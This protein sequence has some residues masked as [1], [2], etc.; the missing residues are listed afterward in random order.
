MADLS[1]EQ[2]TMDRILEKVGL[3]SQETTVKEYGFTVQDQERFTAGKEKLI[4]F[5]DKLE[6][7]ASVIR[8]AEEASSVLGLGLQDEVKDLDRVIEQKFADFI[9]SFYKDE[10]NF[11]YFLRKNVMEAMEDGWKGGLPD[12][13]E[14]RRMMCDIV[15]FVRLVGGGSVSIIDDEYDDNKTKL[16]II[17]P[18]NLSD[19]MPVKSGGYDNPWDMGGRLS[20]QGTEHLLKLPKVIIERLLS[21]GVTDVDTSSDGLNF[22]KVDFDK[23]PYRVI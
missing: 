10:K 12:T 14:T 6:L 9:H 17:F 22:P 3:K 23:N 19:F 8:N 5:K 2:P 21:G 16:R 18:Q 13:P 7:A 11:P 20:S 4:D 15:D 1:L